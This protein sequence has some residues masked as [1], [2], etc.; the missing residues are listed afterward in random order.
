VTTFIEPSLPISMALVRDLLV[1]TLPSTLTDQILHDATVQIGDR[2]SRHKVR[3][4]L[5]DLTAVPVVDKS[6][7]T[8]IAQLAIRNRVLGS[9]TTLI[10]IQPGV[11]AYLA[12]LNQN[13]RFIRFAQTMEFALRGHG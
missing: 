4:V 9:S 7:F 6:D 5:I 8:A 1:V 2:I 10:G 3:G 12:E 11:A 13:T